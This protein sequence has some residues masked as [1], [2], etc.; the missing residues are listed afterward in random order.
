MAS[1][2]VSPMQAK[3][4]ALSR[5]RR[6]T[7]ET[8]WF[9]ALGAIEISGMVD[10]FPNNQKYHKDCG[11]QKENWH[12]FEVR[13]LSIRLW[14]PWMISFPL[15]SWRLLPLPACRSFLSASRHRSV[16]LWSDW[17]SWA[18]LWIRPW[19]STLR[20]TAMRQNSRGNK[21]N[22]ATHIAAAQMQRSGRQQ[23]V[24]HY[25]NS[26]SPDSNSPDLSW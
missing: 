13:L 8:N 25:L 26:G 24:E 10:R 6:R 14:F 22:R 5:R 11:Y 15:A 3:V 18:C 20:R 16:H 21:P 1:S 23:R 7:L 17:P 4:V 12:P 2:I 9:V 19:S